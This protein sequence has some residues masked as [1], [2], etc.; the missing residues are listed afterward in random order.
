TAHR[1]GGRAATEHLLGL[2]HQDIAVIARTSHHTLRGD[3]ERL[4][5]YRSAHAAAGLHVHQ[6]YLR[7]AGCDPEHAYRVAHDLLRLE[8]P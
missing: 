2:G 6:Q 4:A 3:T 8:H 7:Y 1:D 5:G